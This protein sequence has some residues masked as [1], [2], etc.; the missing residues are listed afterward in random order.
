MKI[1][2]SYQLL[3]RG[4]LYFCLLIIASPVLVLAGE[5][6]RPFWT[7]KS[8]YIEGNDLYAVGIASNMATSE[9]GR[10]RAFEQGKIELMNFAQVTDLEVEGLI[11]ETQ[12]TYEEKN[13]DGTS[14]IF[15]LLR[16]DGEKLLEVQ[17]R[18]QAE[19]QVQQESLERVEVGLDTKAQKLARLHQKI[20]ARIK[21]N[22]QKA[23][24][25]VTAGMTPSDVRALLGGP[26]GQTYSI[27]DKGVVWL[28]GT[29]AVHFD[30]QGVV[31]SV[32]GCR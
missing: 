2:Q 29:T 31:S 11:I 20:L 21:A 17:G 19:S 23:C 15:R 4:M 25:Y 9:E 16:V 24:Q 22:S 28:Y 12:M 13:D 3:L 6:A 5:E 1:V 30:Q 8:A 10:Q 14:N 32:G 27:S 18:L 26:R 7:E